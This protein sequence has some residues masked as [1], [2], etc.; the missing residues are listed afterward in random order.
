M[1]KKLKRWSAML[2]AAFLVIGSVEYTGLIAEAE[3]DTTAQEITFAMEGGL[4]MSYNQMTSASW[5]DGIKFDF[6]SQYEEIKFDLPEAISTES[7]KSATFDIFGVTAEGASVS[8][9]LYNGDTQVGVAYNKTDSSGYTVALDGWSSWDAEQPQITKVG[10]MASQNTS[11][12]SGT[13]KGVSFKV[14]EGTV[15]STSLMVGQTLTYGGYKSDDVTYS[16]TDDGALRFYLPASWKQLNLGYSLIRGYSAATPTISECA[17]VSIDVKSTD[18]AFTFGVQSKDSSYTEFFTSEAISAAGT[19]SYNFADMANAGTYAT[20]GLNGFVLKSQ[21]AEVNAEI[22]SVTLTLTNGTVATFVMPEKAFSVNT[23]QGTAGEGTTNVAN[24]TL[25]TTQPAGS[26]IFISVPSGVTMADYDKMT[27]ATSSFSGSG[28]MSLVSSEAKW[29]AAVVSA[30]AE[31]GKFVFDIKDKA[32]YDLLKIGEDVSA[33]VTGI[34]LEKGSVTEVTK[35]FN[36]FALSY[37][38]VQNATWDEVNNKATFAAAYDKLMLKLPVEIDL[39]Q[40]DSV[41]VNLA[42]QNGKKMK[43]WMGSNYG[44]TAEATADDL[45]AANYVITLDGTYET[46]AQYFTIEAGEDGLEVVVESITLVK[47]A[48]SGS[49]PNPGPGTNDTDRVIDSANNV[50]ADFNSNFESSGYWSNASW[51]D[52]PKVAYGDTMDK[53]SE[54]CGAQYLSVTVDAS[55]AGLARTLS[56]GL[57][58][59]FE[60]DKEYEF[61]YYARLAEGST[62]AVVFGVGSKASDYSNSLAANIVYDKEV[63]LSSDAWTKV[64]GTFKMVDPQGMVQIDFSSAAGVSFM[65]DELI[66]AEVT[67][68]DT[69]RVIDSSNNVLENVN[70]NFESSGYW[71][72]ASWTDQPKVAYGD[73][74]DKPSETCGAQYLSVTVDA[75]TAGL[76]RNLSDGLVSSFEKDV[77]YEFTY[78]ARLAEGSTGTVVFGVGSKASD[79]SNSL[80]A[81]IVYDKEVTLSSDAWTKVG[82]TFKMVDPQGMVQIDFSSAAG[83]SFM[84]DE[85]LVAPT[86]AGGNTGGGEGGEE[87]TGEKITY[88]FAQLEEFAGWSNEMTIDDAGKFTSVFTGSY[89]QR[90]FKIPAD[91]DMTKVQKVIFDGFTGSSY[92]LRLLTQADVDGG[93]GST[94]VAVSSGSTLNVG[95]NTDVKYVGFCCKSASADAP[96]TMTADSISFVLYPEGEEAPT[97]S[98]LVYNFNDIPVSSYT[99][100][101]YTVDDRGRAEFTCGGQY[102]YFAFTLPEEIADKKVTHMKLYFSQDAAYDDTFNV[103][104]YE[105]T[106]INPGM[107]D[108]GKQTAWGHNPDNTIAVNVDMKMVALKAPNAGMKALLKKVEFTVEGTVTGGSDFVSD[109]EFHFNDVSKQDGWNSVVSVIESG[110]MTFNSDVQNGETRFVYPAELSE[111]TLKKV[112]LDISIG[113]AENLAI[114]LYT[115]SDEEGSINGFKQVDVAYGQDF[116]D[117]TTQEPIALVGIMNNGT[118]PMNITIDKITYTV[119]GDIEDCGSTFAKSSD[120]VV[121]VAVLEATADTTATIVVDGSGNDVE[122]DGDIKVNFAVAGDAIYYPLTTSADM[123][124]VKYI[125]FGNILSQLG[126]YA[127]DL[128]NDLTGVELQAF[129]END[130]AAKTPTLT[131][132]KSVLMTNGRT[133]LKYFGLVSTTDAVSASFGTLRFVQKNL[134]KDGNYKVWTADKFVAKEATSSTAGVAFDGLDKMTFTFNNADDE[135]I[136]GLPEGL[137]LHNVEDWTFAFSDTETELH[138]TFYDANMNELCTSKEP[139]KKGIYWTVDR[140]M[141]GSA[142]SSPIT[143]FGIKSASETP[144]GATCVFDGISINEKVWPVYSENPTIAD[145]TTITY[146]WKDMMKFEGDGW[147]GATFEDTNDGLLINYGKGYGE[148]AMKLPAMIDLAQCETI[149]VKMNGQTVPV[150]VKIKKNGDTYITN[151]DKIYGTRTFAPYTDAQVNKLSLMCLAEFEGANAKFESIT[152]VMHGKYEPTVLGGDGIV[153]NGDFMDPDVSD[154]KEALWDTATITAETS[155]T[156]IYD[157]VTTY[158]NYANRTSP[159]QGFAQDLTGRVQQNETYK[160]SFWAKLSDDYKGAPDV[161]RVISFSPYTVDKDGVADYNP[162]LQ[163]TYAQVCEVGE[164]TYYEGTWKVTNANEIGS[165]YIRIIEQGTNYGQGDCVLGDYA[166]TGVNIEVYVPDPPSIDEDVPN[167]KDE[168]TADFGDDFIVGTAIAGN[169]FDDIGVEMLANKHFNAITLGNELKPDALMSYSETHTP[170]TTA[171]INGQTIEVPTLRFGNADARLDQILEWNES[172]PDSPIR[173][174]G[175]VLVWHSQTMEW[176]FREGYV[177]GQ[178]ADGTENYVTPEVMNLRL[179]WYIKTVL[180]HYVG[181]DSKYKDLFYGWDVVNEAVGDGT[182]RYRTNTVVK[183]E[184]PSDTRHGSNSSWWAVYQSNEFIINAFKYANKYAPADVELYYNDYN[185]CDTKK[186]QGICKLLNDVLAEE[187]TRIDAMGMQAH[188]NIFNPGMG[189]FEKTIRAYCAVVG[190]VQLTELDLKASGDIGSES[191]LQSEYEKQAEHYNKIYNVL[192]KLDAEEGIEIGGVT[193]WGTIDTYSWLQSKSNVG[194]ASDGTMKQCPLLFDGSYKVKPAYWAWV[195]YS[196]IDPDYVQ[197]EYDGSTAP[198]TPAADDKTEDK[199]TEASSDSSESIEETTTV[200]VTVTTD[201]K[202]EG[203][204]NVAPIAAGVAAAVVVVGAGVGAVVLKKKKGLPKK[205]K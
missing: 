44:W 31:D 137:N 94:T 124:L 174:R 164:W 58:S 88:T 82:G 150:A 158:G 57:V 171:T 16:T 86:E 193:F 115:E 146:T 27:V 3:G 81:N 14:E 52:Q 160:F 71:S 117:V 147:S 176:F 189:T 12:G 104:I 126:L 4:A 38:D 165:V 205:D 182:G 73:T 33:T 131:S 140:T 37:W 72:N 42:S 114:K 143:Y 92:E 25:T 162:N 201:D 56:D 55:T 67:S 65:I 123:S 47:N 178:N 119:D 135:A 120:V 80:A 134:T 79:Y 95:A 192:R 102:S 99:D 197:E 78:Y 60:K 22:N 5:A 93:Y 48:T 203:G 21:S 76:A 161:Q 97:T 172:H 185:E 121:P 15:E 84:I 23:D 200:T 9:K 116:L 18:A 29:G 50:I 64:G 98:T 35:T 170:L 20:D 157:N 180:E 107:G 138:Y 122:A 36:K 186:V 154:W 141:M 59:T 63:T 167:L 8:L 90:Y 91:I 106:D 105:S 168:L 51:T 128:G 191:G 177:I 10:I 75:S 19:Y 89:S 83:V 175:H 152:F 17:S 190:K 30:T 61:T 133:D 2:L 179:E 69:D 118:T 156:P 54:T 62:G 109:V 39:S 112:A 11:A 77:V 181:E 187:G 163:G 43:A 169:E 53:P 6:T 28:T 149:S 198:S 148:I 136:F 32:G 74:M 132:N 68:N 155:A 113:S 108:N 66:I 40:Y 184:L 96:V 87:E 139:Y 100:A 125:D 196:Q 204:S 195:D 199:N 85:L 173:V 24:G 194:G 41:K 110:R 70:S 111:A 145:Y 45:A 127:S 188:Y 34:T 1:W 103:C 159:Y 7:F 183:T 151:Y 13:F 166:V 49:E 26:S 46:P 202:K 130:Y 142:A 144:A 129:T 101:T 153:I